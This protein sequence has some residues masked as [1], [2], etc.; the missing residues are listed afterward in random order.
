MLIWWL[1]KKPLIAGK[2]NIA[3]LASFEFIANLDLHKTPL[4]VSFKWEDKEMK[5]LGMK[6]LYNCVIPVFP[7]TVPCSGVE[8]VKEK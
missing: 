1:N 3:G 8:D 6:S 4:A 2:K 7:I 5:E